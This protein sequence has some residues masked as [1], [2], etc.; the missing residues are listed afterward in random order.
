MTTLETCSITYFS[1]YLVKKCL[2]KYKCKICQKQLINENKNLEDT[3]LILILNKSF[4]FIE[5]A[6]GLKAPSNLIIKNTTIC[7]NTFE[8]HFDQIK[9]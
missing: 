3:N 7:L 1:R 5:Q 2:E 6:Q 4:N 9:S 8:E